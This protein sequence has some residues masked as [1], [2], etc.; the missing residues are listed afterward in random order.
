[1]ITEKQ[2]AKLNPKQ[3]PFMQ[4]ILLKLL[5]PSLKQ[6][7]TIFENQHLIPHDRA[8]I[9][10]MNHTDRFNYVPFMI[11]LWFDYRSIAPW[12]KGKY[13]QNPVMANILDATNNIPVP[14]RG[15]LITLDFHQAMHRRPN[16]EEY[17]LLRDYVDGKLSG[18]AFQ[19]R[20]SV[21]VRKF[22]TMRFTDFDPSQQTYREYVQRNYRQ[23]MRWVSDLS[24]NVLQ[25]KNLSL[26]IFPEGTRSVRLTP[27]HPGI[28]QIALKTGVPVIPVGCNGSEKLYPGA[29]PFAK[30]GTVTYRIG[31]P[32]TLDG[33]LAP[34]AIAEPFEPFTPE[35]EAKYGGIFQAAT[36]TIMTKINALLD[37]E[38]Q[39]S[40]DT[41]GI[42]GTGAHRFV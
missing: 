28:A 11:H 19:H 20:A 16:T 10:V 4:R 41:H 25:K 24:I 5:S 37:P 17:R 40:G 7:T 14:S 12:V 13:Y 32:L 18:D 15:Y 36:D 26:L 35:T 22:M 42:S 39:F 34:Y 33:V 29:S 9:F 21:A 6:V 1:M 23:F 30:P 38:Y 2:F 31:E 27:G 8:V 3:F